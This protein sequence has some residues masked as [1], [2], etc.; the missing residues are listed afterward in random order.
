MRVLHSPVEHQH[1]NA[2]ET[3]W[4]FLHRHSDYLDIFVS[5]FLTIWHLEVPGWQNL[6]PWILN[7][8]PDHIHDPSRVLNPAGIR[9]GPS[10]LSRPPNK[11]FF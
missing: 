1:S 10:L 6:A 11:C 5:F 7:M 9:T 4:S 8:F 3:L 2:L